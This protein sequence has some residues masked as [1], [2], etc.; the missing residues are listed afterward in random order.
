[1]LGTVF[2]VK[3]ILYS[4]SL[5]LRELKQVVPTFYRL[6]FKIIIPHIFYSLVLVLHDLGSR[7]SFTGWKTLPFLTS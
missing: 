6:E 5:I 3:E 7:P 2:L 1:M 4:Q